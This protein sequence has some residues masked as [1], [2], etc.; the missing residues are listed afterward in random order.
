MPLGARRT[1]R[2][3]AVVA[4]S[5]VL[6]YGLATPMPFLAPI[7]AVLLTA[8]PAP[9]MGPKQLLGLLV[10]VTI[11]LGIGLVLMPLL[12][13]YPIS[14]VMMIAAG[15][16]ASTYLGVGKGKAMVGTLLTIG[17]TMIP[18][19]G[20]LEITL[21]RTV[22]KGLL[23]GIGMVVVCQWIV[24]PLFPEDP[25]RVAPPKA[26]PADPQ[27]AAWL[28]L[29]TM[30]IVL[31]S[32][33]LA[34]TNPTLYMPLIM[35]SVM[36][37]QQGCLVT[38]RAAGYELLGSTFLGGA[39]AIAFWF[40]LKFW[41]SLW[42]FGLW[43]LLF[44]MFFGAKLYRVIATRYPA[45]F[46]INVGVTMLILLGPAVQDSAGSD[47]SSAFIR[48]FSLFVLVTVYAWFAI[49]LLEWLRE[50]TSSRSASAA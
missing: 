31:P 34:F 5:L 26:P 32:V 17:L 7:F 35:K 46:W 49:L 33:M 36:L 10:V 43:M 23:I 41:P 25:V 8:A 13:T 39:F 16:F 27:T 20:L 4:L 24:Y 48:R 6:A 1:F 40:V 19:A 14:A 42:M 22:V 2:F 15:L 21:A 44:G 30:L 38:A 37:G 45:S 47:P 9:P 29:R 50:R 11:T 3:G 18:A 12:R 28:A